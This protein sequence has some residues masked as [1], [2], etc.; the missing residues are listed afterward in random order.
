MATNIKDYSTTQASNTSLNSIFVGEGMLPSNL[1]NAIRALMKN[2]RDWFN[3]AEWIEYGDGSGAY[4]SAYV[5]GTSFTIAGADVTSV[6][7]AGRRVK[8][9][10]PTPGTIYGTISSSSFSTDTTVNVTWDSGSLSNEAITNIF[11][12]ILSKTNNSIPTELITD[13]QV[14]T[15]ANIN[16]AKLGTGVVDNTE[17]N[18]LNGVTSN[19][20]T[21]LDAKQATITGGASTITSSNLTVSRALE[22]NGSGKVAVSSVTSTELGYLSGVTSA[23]Q[24]QFSNKQPLDAQLTDIAGLTPTDSNFIVGDGTNFVAESG[25]TVRTSLGL[26]SIATQDSNNVTITGGSITGMSTPSLGSDVTTKT[27]VDDLVAGL[28]TRIITRLATTAN[29]DLATDLENGDTLDGVSLVTGNK[30]LV[31]DQ[32]NQTQNGIYIVPASGAASRDPDFDTVAELAGQLVIIQEGSTNADKIYLCTTDNSG[33]IGSVN[34]TFSQVQPQFTGT[35]SSVAVADAGS[36]E[37]TVSGSPITSSGTITLAVNSIDASKIGNGDVSNTELSYVNGVT[38]AIQTQINGKLANVVEDTT[39]QLGG[40]LD[41]NTNS[42]VSVSNGNIAITPN[43]TGSVVIDG[44]SHPQADGSAGQFLKTDGSGN[45]SFDTV[46]TAATVLTT[47]GDIL[48]RDGSG[49]QRLGAG[50]AGQV[51]QTGG[52]AAN[53]SWTDLSSSG[54]IL[55]TVSATDSSSRTTLSTTYTTA[56]NTLSLTLTPAATSSKVLVTFAFNG[57]N[58]DYD[59]RSFYTI[60]RDI[61]GGTKTN[62]APNGNDMATHEV[63]GSGDMR[64]NF[65]TLSYLDS[66]NT[67]SSVTYTVEVK[68][69]LNSTA[70]LGSEGTGNSYALE[71]GA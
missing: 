47:Q 64:E 1:N 14:A 56:S 40:N 7:H 26:G 29:L 61:S 25:A 71:I 46:S 35:V 41:V 69:E 51:L 59:Y 2:T 3:D 5:S 53:P 18:Y 24:T 9:I 37:F 43:G 38:S 34:I 30:I 33:S 50:T 12:G 60:F 70:Y 57:G 6:Y 15:G 48:Y 19:I 42:I 28:K 55:Q 8:V 16:A 49:L 21:Q 44:L 32:T 13:A 68:A 66:P 65:M 45:L 10:A 63:R 17:F 23:I 54:G 39:P 4:T 31:K 27:Y 58:S 52:A 20:Q 62:L 22:S 36:S 67:T 11:I